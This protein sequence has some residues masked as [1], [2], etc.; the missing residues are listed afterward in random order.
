MLAAAY[1][2]LN[3]LTLLLLLLDLW[4]RTRVLCFHDVYRTFSR[5]KKARY[6]SNI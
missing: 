4:Y 6:A 1:Q 5:P 3:P 2:G